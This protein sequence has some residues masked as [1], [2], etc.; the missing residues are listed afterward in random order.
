M[1]ANMSD[2]VE[3]PVVV[4]PLCEKL[5]RIIDNII[6]SISGSDKA[7]YDREFKFFDQV[8]GISGTLQQYLHCTKAEKKAKIDE[9]MEKIVVDPGV[10]LPSNPESIVIGIDQKSGRPLQ[11]HAKTPFMATFRIKKA[12]EMY[13]KRMS[14]VS[15]AESSGMMGDNNSRWQQA[16]FKVGDDCRQDI[17]A[18]QLICIFKNIFQ[19]A[20]I[21]VYLF[22]YRVVATNPG[23]C[24]FI[25]LVWCY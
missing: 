12:T 15:L 6:N 17:L 5:L 11:S 20:G 10:Y 13:T 4:D 8:T 2:N 24:N 21:D 19:K 18:L 25:N 1:N 22:P 14:I 23:V 9:E 3:D 16:I 7:F